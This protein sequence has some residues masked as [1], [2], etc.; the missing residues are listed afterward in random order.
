MYCAEYRKHTFQ[1][2]QPGGTSRGILYTKP[3][4]Y[5][6]V[7]KEN[8][9]SVYGMG[10]CS[11]IPGLSPD[12][13]PDLEEKLQEVCHEINFYKEQWRDELRAWPAI[14]FALECAVRDLEK[15][16]RQILFPSAF[17]RGEESIVINGLIW[18][19]QP[20][21]MLEQI[22]TKLENGFSCLKMKIG[23]IDFEQ[24]LQILNGIRQ[25]FSAEDLTLRVDANGAFAPHES[26]QK[27][28][29][30]SQYQLHSIEQPI[31]AGQWEEMARLCEKTPVP[32]ALDEELIGINH[33]SE[34]EQLLKQVQPQYIILKPS[35][36][37]G[38]MEADE[39]IELAQ[40]NKVGW[41]ITSALEGNVGLNAIAQWTYWK[42]S[43]L[44]Q[45]LGTG[46]VFTN[47][48]HSPLYLEGE[49]LFHSAQGGWDDPFQIAE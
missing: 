3:S 17:T 15:G 12:D 41:W 39:W 40:E 26:L 30:L 38:L 9:P 10:E 24:E 27:L 33:R 21:F 16:G 37:G 4:W 28:E 11:V 13:R 48:V 5:L 44:P 1:F 22:E 47:N 46:Q 2:K 6:K 8:E 18:M 31:K 7:W 14:Q 35:L 49:Q 36:V 25:R 20:E 42:N 34:K 23:A 43:Q 29:R 32:V 45:G 19:G